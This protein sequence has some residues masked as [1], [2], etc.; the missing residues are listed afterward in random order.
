MFLSRLARLNV[1][2]I[3]PLAAQGLTSQRLFSSSLVSYKTNTSTRTK[4][5]VHDLKTF[6]ELIGRDT[7]EHH[8]SFEGDL[9]K[10]LDTSSKEMKA[11]GIDVST[12]R[13][14]LRWKN[15]FI[16]DLEPL[17]EHQRGKKRNG[18]ERKEKQVLAQRKALKRKEE[19]QQFAKDRA[20]GLVSDER[21][22]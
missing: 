10:F 14:M 22:F 15:K 1:I 18:G 7:I 8:D 20:A 11:M 2:S 17:R 6:F 12:R 9:Q 21:V 3:K 4:E 19:R 16:N 5:N 13:Y